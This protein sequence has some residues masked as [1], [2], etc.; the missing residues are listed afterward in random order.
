MSHQVETMA[1]M[2]DTPWHGLGNQL[3]ANQS[4]ENWAKAAG[5][6]WNIKSAE[7]TYLAKN[8]FNQNL[9][10]PFESNK[11]L[12][13]SDTM[14]PLS[15]VSQRYKEVQPMEI[16]EFYRDLT[17]HANFELE[18]AGVLQGGKKIWALARTGQD[19]TLKGGDTSKG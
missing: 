6:N 16:L 15:V 11:V 17:T 10:M 18:T 9:I 5:M 4:I 12:Y 3:P 13:R 7:V 19:S 14:N 8:E 1:F 2:G